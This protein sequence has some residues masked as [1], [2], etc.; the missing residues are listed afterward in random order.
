MTLLGRPLT[1]A[2][3][4]SCY[5]PD[6]PLKWPR[7]KVGVHSPGWRRRQDRVASTPG[8]RP[9]PQPPDINS[10]PRWHPATGA[11]RGC[12]RGPLPTSRPRL[13]HESITTTIDT[14]AHLLPAGDELIAEV[15]QTALAGG[16]I[17]LRMRLVTGGVV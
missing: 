13:G 5:A 10:L 3:S 12:R 6:G 8:T 14:Y 2:L 4:T 9:S 17:R 1:Y 11:S 15:I 16:Q 7:P